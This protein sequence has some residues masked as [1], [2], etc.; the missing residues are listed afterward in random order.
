MDINTEYSIAVGRMEQIDLWLGL[1]VHAAEQSDE[2]GKVDKIERIGEDEVALLSIDLCDLHYLCDQLLH[3]DTRIK[4]DARILRCI[5][6]RDVTGK[7]AGDTII[8]VYIK[9]LMGR[10]SVRNGLAMMAEFMRAWDAECYR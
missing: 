3:E 7:Y 9:Q 2:V 4:N 1:A 5:D 8:K 6:Y 10:Y